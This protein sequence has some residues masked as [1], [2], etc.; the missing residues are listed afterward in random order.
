MSARDKNG[1]TDTIEPQQLDEDCSPGV[2]DLV[3][4]RV[5]DAFEKVRAR[6]GRQVAADEDRFATWRC[7]TKPASLRHRKAAALRRR[8]SQAASPEQRPIRPS[9]VERPR[10]ASPSQARATDRATLR[11]SAVS[12]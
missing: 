3:N 4:Y 1:A 10:Q 5:S 11:A 2:G 12:T 7:L 8:P 6:I 9:P